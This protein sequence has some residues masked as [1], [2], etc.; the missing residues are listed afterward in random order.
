MLKDLDE[1]T[2]VRAGPT[3]LHFAE[4]YPAFFEAYRQA[5]RRYGIDVET[6]PPARAVSMIRASA[7]EKDLIAAIDEWANQ[8][9][10]EVRSHL[11]S[12]ARQLDV[13]PMRNAIRDAMVR[14]DR[15]ELETLSRVLV[16]QID[17]SQYPPTWLSMG[18]NFFTGRSDPD[19]AI[20]ILVSAQRFYPNHFFVNVNL[21]RAYLARRPPKYNEAIR[22]FSIA[23]ALRPDSTAAH[24]ELGTALRGSGDFDAAKKEYERTIDIVPGHLA[25]Y[26]AIA[27]I[28]RQQG[29]ST[30]ALTILTKARGISKRLAEE[31]ADTP[32]SLAALA[33][34]QIE[35]GDQLSQLG[36]NTEASQ[37]FDEAL[38]TYK[39]CV[40]SDAGK[41]QSDDALVPIHDAMGTL[42]NRMGRPADAIESFK[43]ALAI[44]E[45]LAKTRPKILQHQVNLAARLDRI[46]E[47]LSI[48]GRNAAAIDSLRKALAIS[49]R[50]AREYP[51][52]AESAS[53]LGLTL[54]HL[55]S[56]EHSQDWLT[57]R[58]RI[59]EGIEHQ[60]RAQMLDPGN[61]AFPVHLRNQWIGLSAVALAH[62]D[63][64]EASAAAW[65]WAAMVPGK[66]IDLDNAARCLLR[67]VRL[68]RRTAERERYADEA[69]K[70]FRTVIAAGSTNTNATA[71]DADT[72]PLTLGAYNSIGYLYRVTRRPA[73]AL[74]AYLKAKGI[75]E[76]L[77][78][79][80]PN[81]A[82]VASELGSTLHGLAI[83]ESN[84]DRS[85]ARDKLRQA[86]AHQLRAL[87]LNP[88][89]MA[90]GL[91]LTNH[92]IALHRI[93][94]A[95]GV[96]P[97]GF[98]SGAGVDQSD[99]RPS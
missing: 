77:V 55:G 31:R 94:P 39:R 35:I 97:E 3:A 34:N 86:L 20:A 29:Q 7:I 95:Q 17:I 67:C 78:R 18:G 21:G 8:S 23:V 60:R 83:L 53:V 98:R 36:R 84:R 13:H 63:A 12:I 14:N 19:T 56:L 87:S 49:E 81:S 88:G 45:H 54:H 69:I 10:G 16:R 40:R 71:G 65:A 59:R 79:E 85:A 92:L 22:F 70:T 26:F 93:A 28:C 80:R 44:R 15:G 66:P 50:L 72:F 96:P 99:G 33:A 37:S 48:T 30:E 43:E 42:L 90:Y 73:D 24:D 82:N 47:L 46:G 11:V 58:N 4:T 52:S 6:L 27:D 75:G 68:A 41:N 91:Y 64:A 74:E 9:G 25:A 61:V 57:G 62:G 51:E 76:R 5:F 32:S 89:H 2:L 38:A 1:A